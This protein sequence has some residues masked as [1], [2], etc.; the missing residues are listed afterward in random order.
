M[1]LNRS[2]MMS[3][4]SDF[5]KIFS[6]GSRHSSTIMTIWIKPNKQFDSIVG[7][8]VS[9]KVGNSVKRNLIRRRLKEIVKKILPDQGWII[10]ISAKPSIVNRTFNQIFFDLKNILT[11]NGVLS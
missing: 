8:S 10:F 1:N 3:R 5:E 4:P 11:I 2:Q 6:Q 7:F 9:K